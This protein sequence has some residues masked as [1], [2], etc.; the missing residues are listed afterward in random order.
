MGWHF[1]SLPPSVLIEYGFEVPRELALGVAPAW[2]ASSTATAA[3]ALVPLRIGMTL[4]NETLAFAIL[5]GLSLLLLTKWYWLDSAVALVFSF[6][7]IITGYKLLRRSLAGI[8]DE[9]E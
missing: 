6:V 4:A 9:S 8:M 2:H 7:I 1:Q 3:L 5:A